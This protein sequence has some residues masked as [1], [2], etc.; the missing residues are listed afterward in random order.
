MEPA[1]T[2]T[3]VTVNTGNPDAVTVTV[4]SPICKSWK[5]NWPSAVDME[6]ATIPVALFVAF[7]V[8]PGTAAPEG[9]VTAP[10]IAPRKVCALAGKAKTSTRKSTTSS[11][12]IFFHNP[13]ELT[14]IGRHRG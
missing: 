7:T 8:A 4:Y 9:S 2:V 6:D 11:C 10:L 13:L 1:A 5:E 12:F 3:S 14:K